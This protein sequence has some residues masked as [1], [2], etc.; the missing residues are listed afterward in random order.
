MD[1]NLYMKLYDAKKKLIQVKDT[2]LQVAKLLVAFLELLLSPIGTRGKYL[3][4][5]ILGNRRKN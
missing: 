1:Q 3:R 4:L 2:K 5:V